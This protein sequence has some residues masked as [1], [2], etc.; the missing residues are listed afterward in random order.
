MDDWK[1]L[2]KFA[3]GGSE[4]AFAEI[5]RRHT[6]LVYSAAIETGVPARARPLPVNV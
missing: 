1:L 5:V 4:A 6:D 3:E 2:R